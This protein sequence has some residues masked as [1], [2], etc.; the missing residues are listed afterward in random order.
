MALRYSIITLLLTCYFIAVGQTED[1]RIAHYGTEDGLP[2]NGI[3]GMQWDKQ[4]GF[5]WVA[6]E[7]GLVRYNGMTFKTYTN[8]DNKQITNERMLFLVKNNIGRIYT[9]DN[10][11]NIFSIQENNLSFYENISISG[12]SKNNAIS[13][14]VSETLFKKKH[15]FDNGPFT[16]QFDRVLPINDTSCIIN[17]NEK[18]FYFS[19]SAASPVLWTFPIKKL[20]TPFKCRDKLFVC[21]EN[22]NIWLIDPFSKS[23]GKT[24]IEFNAANVRIPVL[25]KSFLAW[26]TGMECPI[27]VDGENAWKISYENERLIATIICTIVPQDALIRYAQYD[28]HRGT[29]FLGT[30]SKGII[31]IRK[32]KV[33]QLR[34]K[35]TTVSQRTS[36]YSQL[37]LPD[38]TIMTNE[39]H[40]LGKTN[41]VYTAL[42]GI[43][44]FSISTYLMGDSLF[45]FMA[46]NMELGGSRLNCY[47]LKT[48][49]LKKFDKIRE[50]YSQLVMTSVNGILYVAN[51]LGISY[52]EGDSLKMLVSYS[53][54]EKPQIHFDIKETE[55]GILHIAN[56]NAL[57]RYDIAKNKLEKVYQSGNYCVRTIWQYKEYLFFGTYGNGLYISKNGKVKPLPL[58]KNGYL[59]FT[60]CFVE[61][62]EG[63]CWISTN[64]GL[65]KTSIADMINAYEN[66]LSRIYYHYFG[67]NDGMVM[68]EMNGGCLPCAITLRNN[69]ISFPTMDGLLWVNPKE[70]IPSLPDGEI[71]VDEI[72][73][74]NKRVDPSSFGQTPIS[75]GKH[76]L[77]IRLG[78]SAWCNKE[79]VYLEYQL[80]DDNSWRPVDADH[81]AVFSFNNLTPGVYN[82]RI[83]KMNGFGRDNY[84]YKEISFV[85]STPW[86]QRWWFYVACA[87]LLTVLIIMYFNFRTNQFKVRQRRLEKQVAEKTKELQYQN[88]V[89]EKNNSIKTRL[90]SIISHD[91]VTPLKFLTAAGKNLLEK[92][93]LMSEDLQQ[94]TVRE[95]T[96]TSQELQLLSTN[97][98]NWIKYQNE[99]RRMVKEMFN[100][101]EMVAQVLGI[102][103]TLARQKSL[104]IENNVNPSIE[105]NQFYEPLK[106]LVYNLLTNAIQFTERGTIAVTTKTENGHIVVSVKD[107]GIG[108]SPEQ[109]QRLLEEEVV[110]TA[111]NVDNKKGHG[112]GYLIIK[113][114]LKTIGGG[115]EIQSKKGSGTTVLIKLP[116]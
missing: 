38:G 11:G 85:I 19:I 6:T 56:C 39:G 58:D 22:N 40:V 102:L 93:K 52:L 62:K 91:I 31:I 63:F 23:L 5:L 21:D 16:L 9:A 71:F 57:L 50:N 1:F 108:M 90:I 51:E 86:Y 94:E 92:K 48:K 42:T 97:I 111:A 26:E 33:T 45:W 65:F 10:T 69:T 72:M 66:D 77:H 3:K 37:A 15:Q 13:L 41:P 74:D 59:Q 115:I 70:A 60:H 32:N 88:E 95:M 98:L 73:V 68:T 84:S 104:V 54:N 43:Q 99:N 55:P 114:L 75:P 109:I 53:A 47:N 113:D 44:K 28:E 61:D 87:G 17:R 49:M 80:G 79:N 112:L 4:T 30:D 81:G 7:A 14:G 29:L 103:Q 18:I 24:K 36:Y 34:K 20:K 35:R 8:D 105:I 83:R 89:L 12:N 110:I 27:L 116:K 25:T 101:H 2:S 82:I 64:H 106:I 100:L 46:Q 96:N 67:L 107:E 76:D 78:F